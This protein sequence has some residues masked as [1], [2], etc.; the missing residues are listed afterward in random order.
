MNITHK[1][2]ADLVEIEISGKFSLDELYAGFEAMIHDPALP[3][4]A[5]LM[6]NVT[7]SEVLPPV[8]VIERIAMILGG[9]RKK[10][11]G[12]VAVLVAQEVRYGRAR[13][14]GVFLSNYGL[15]AQPFYERDE[16]AKWLAEDSFTR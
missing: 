6:I 7:A 8:E 12:R 4:R 10:L 14:L 2:G 1:I 15:E 3:E 16:A 13:Q 9:A 11:S 5:R